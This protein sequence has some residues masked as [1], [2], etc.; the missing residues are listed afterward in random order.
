MVPLRRCGHIG[1]TVVA[2]QRQLEEEWP[3]ELLRAAGHHSV[4]RLEQKDKER[5]NLNEWERAVCGHCFSVL[6]SSSEPGAKQVRE[7]AGA[8]VSIAPVVRK[9]SPEDGS[10]AARETY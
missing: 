3:K 2:F 6:L 4:C 10:R 5:E 7:R 1:H 9:Q 8:L